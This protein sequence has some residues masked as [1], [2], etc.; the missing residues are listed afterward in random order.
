[1]LGLKGFVRVQMDVGLLALS[2]YVLL[3]QVCLDLAG[4]AV[5]L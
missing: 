5:H 1:M 4:H 3:R 2:L